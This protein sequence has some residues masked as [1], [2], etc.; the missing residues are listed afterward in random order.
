MVEGI[1]HSSFEEAK[2]DSKHCKQCSWVDTRFIKNAYPKVSDLNNHHGSKNIEHDAGDQDWQEGYGPDVLDPFKEFWVCYLTSGCLWCFSGALRT[3]CHALWWEGT[4]WSATLIQRQYPPIYPNKE[5]DAYSII[6]T[7]QNFQLDV[8]K[9]K[10]AAN[11]SG[12][13]ENHKALK[14]LKGKEQHKCGTWTAQ[15]Q[16]LFTNSWQQATGQG[17]QLS[18][19]HCLPVIVYT[20]A[21]WYPPPYEQSYGLAT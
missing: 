15:L 20:K 12:R 1:Q 18:C 9:G 19:L 4:W 8:D 16:A 17:P 14:W 10:L 7:G 2:G 13:S 6:S 3:P 21:S 11:R 5:S